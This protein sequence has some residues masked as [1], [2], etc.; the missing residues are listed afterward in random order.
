MTFQL[1]IM[2]TAFHTPIGVYSLET[3]LQML[4]DLG[5]SGYYHACFEPRE[6]AYAA[7]LAAASARTGVTIA[8]LSFSIDLSGSQPAWSVDR[9]IER[10][11]RVEA[12]RRVELAL[13]YHDRSVLCSDPV[14]DSAALRALERLLPIA[15]KCD[16]TLG[17]Y[18]HCHDW[19]E[20][21][22]D[23]LRLAAQLKH[24]RLGC[25]FCG[26]HWYFRDHRD[27]T[28]LH[29]QFQTAQRTA[30]RIVGVNLNGATSHA[31]PGGR[32]TIEPLGQ[33]DLDNLALLTCLHDVGY[34]G[35]ID[36]QGFSV[37]GDVYAQLRRTRDSLDDMTGRLA[38]H[39]I[40]GRVWETRA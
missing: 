1:A 15:E 17:L 25:V 28:H 3:R 30:G 8:G 22:S 35:W 39:P 7:D 23:S 12:T 11:S 40:W 16:L 2:N 33:G 37:G 26:F 19:L 29:Q 20:R 5:I 21:F 18:P 13:C 14:G 27:L 24:P 9:A 38:R 32:P 4:A 36:V 6:D 31:E 34:R 10:L